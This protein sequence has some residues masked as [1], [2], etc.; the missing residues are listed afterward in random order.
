MGEERPLVLPC[1]TPLHKNER[2]RY[3]EVR[4]MLYPLMNERW[5]CSEERPLYLQNQEFSHCKRMRG[6][7]MV[8]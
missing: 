1:K 4:R 7:G 3:G 6:G 2:W 8:K 5:R